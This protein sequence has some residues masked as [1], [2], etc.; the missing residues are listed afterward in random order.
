MKGL[1]L[2]L[3]CRQ[4]KWG[5]VFL[6]LIIPGFIFAQ[7]S[8]V[9][10]DTLQQPVEGVQVYKNNTILLGI[11]DNNGHIRLQ[12]I[13]T[14]ANLTF[15]LLGYRTLSLPYK[16]IKENGDTVVL[17]RIH[18][19]MD[20]IVIFGR[21]IQYL[22]DII[23]ETAI[24][25]FQ[26]I[27]ETEAKTTADALAMSGKVFVQKSQFGGGS[28]VLR[29][30]E[31][32]RVLLVV[33]GVRMNNAIYRNGHLQNSITID[34]FA[35]KR[36]EI[37]FGAGTLAFGSDAIGGVIH[38]K[39]KDPIFNITNTGLHLR[40]SS[41]AREKTGAFSFNTGNKRVANI[42][43]FSYSDFDDLRAGSKR[44]EEYPDFGKRK[45][46]A[47]RVNNK[48]TIIPNPD[49]NKQIG[50]AYSQY[51]FLNKT[52][53]KIN[54][55]IQL[56]ANIQYSNSS[57]IPRYDFLTEYKKGKLK[58]ADWHYAPQERF[59]ASFNA[60]MSSE[61][62]ALYDKAT[63]IAALQKIKEGRISRKFGDN[64][65]KYNLEKLWV[66]SLS[67]DFKKYIGGDKNYELVYGSDL[68][69]ND[70]QSD[71]KR[72]NI[73]SGTIDKK[74]LTRYPPGLA[75]GMRLGAYMQFI[76][77]EQSESFKVSAGYRVEYNN[78]KVRYKESELVKWDKH[79]LEGLENRNWSSA[80]SVGFKYDFWQHL[81]LSFNTSMAFRNPNI[82]DLAKIRVKKGEMLVPN[83]DL[84]PEKSYNYEV[85]LYRKNNSGNNGFYFT[86]TGFYTLLKNAII[87]KDF[88]LPDGE[89]L[90]ID[91]TDT[92]KIIAN[93]NA[94]ESKIY[95]LSLEAGYKYRSWKLT[96]A[97]VYTKGY[98]YDKGTEM[99]AP[100]IP[101]L[102]GNIKLAYV[103]KKYAVSFLLLFNG[104]KPLNEYGGSVDNPELATEDG[105]YAWTTYNFYFKYK[106][107]NNLSFNAGIENIM[108]IHY[109][110]FASGIS[111]PGRNFIA[112]INAKF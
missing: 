84:K 79:Y 51:N 8:I 34:N 4:L 36:I 82:D 3:C 11:S 66:Y 29:G 53:I 13:D 108:D 97:A 100:H 22:D 65:K 41:A 48:D 63:L 38:F 30:F 93:Q 46:Y 28:P 75:T 105:T 5:I 10:V 64:L 45:E 47:D 95:G 33:D 39:T 112:A 57:D 68:Q 98:V 67:G 109:R 89:P 69:Y 2:E 14:T 72:E 87:R 40:Y 37:L 16:K 92:L 86:S 6:A 71:A 101:P 81:G 42:F 70:L 50:T 18:N 102:Y 91:G 27:T 44:P 35:L 43:I 104:K 106:I 85:A 83:P 107:N 88:H 15:S 60:D 103:H 73:V 49:Y 111:A 62:S 94:G 99:P 12:N 26:D 24:I 96:S 23:P 76:Y 31:A 80:Y 74:I 55:N 78:T 77:G 7:I 20:E 110:P 9:A 58:Y 59:F 32:N 52:K 56:L 54:G 21:N 90:Y 19:N 61:S 1:H 17:S 25:T